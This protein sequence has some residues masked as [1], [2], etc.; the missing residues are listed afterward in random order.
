METVGQALASY[1]RTLNSADSAFDRWHFGK[2]SIA[3]SIEAQHGFDLFTGKAGCSQCHTIEAQ[4]ALFSDQLRHNTGIG[5][6]DSMQQSKAQPQLQIAP[7]VAI[8]VD[9]ASLTGLK[10]EAAND[11]GYY[12]ITQ[13]PEDR[14]AYKTPSLRNVA[15]TAPY[16]HNG[17]L[18]NLTEVINFYNQGGIP[19][20]NLSPLIKPLGLTEKEVADLVSFLTSLT[21][22]N[23]STLVSDAFAAPIGEAH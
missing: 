9:P 1:Q 19:N 7:G 22:S 2:Q 18:I 13:K 4:H 23:V 16:M 8:N 10:R 12:E 3:L 20:E 21:G 11:L 5:Y 6:A 14:W 17:S 15:L